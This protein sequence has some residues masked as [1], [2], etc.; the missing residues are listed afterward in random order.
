MKRRSAKATAIQCQSDSEHSCRVR[1]CVSFRVVSKTMGNCYCAPVAATIGTFNRTNAVTMS[2]LP[3]VSLLNTS[4]VG[5]NRHDNETGI[6][7]GLYPIPRTCILPPSSLPGRSRKA[8]FPLSTRTNVCVSALPESSRKASTKPHGIV[9]AAENPI[10]T[11]F[12]RAVWPGARPTIPKVKSV[13]A[14]NGI[15]C[16]CAGRAERNIPTRRAQDRKQVRLLI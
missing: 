14:G 2:E 12:N 6:N 9:E 3:A 8:A 5:I 10:L 4:S 7:K 11:T 1:R 13:G 15:S 16:P